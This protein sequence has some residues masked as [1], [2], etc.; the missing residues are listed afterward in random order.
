M[1]EPSRSSFKVN[2]RDDDDDEDEDGEIPRR[3]VL[4]LFT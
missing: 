4:L 3:N 1:R 2:K